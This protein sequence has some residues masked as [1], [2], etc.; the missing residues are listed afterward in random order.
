MIGM[1][2]SSETLQLL[3]A[4]GRR[5]DP[6]AFGV[7]QPASR[8]GDAGDGF[9][10]GLETQH[11]HHGYR[12]TLQQHLADPHPQDQRHKDQQLIHLTHYYI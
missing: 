10:L 2:T 11:R 8:Q 7:E 6:A 1:T 5:V 4:Q 12:H 9:G 3:L